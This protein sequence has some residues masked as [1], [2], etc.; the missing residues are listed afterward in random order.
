MITNQMFVKFKKKLS[1]NIFISLIVLFLGIG[2]FCF[3]FYKQVI[4]EEEAV[5]FNDI[6][7]GDGKKVG[8]FSYLDVV[9]DA[10]MF[11]QYDNKDDYCYFVYDENYYYIIRM[12]EKKYKE[13]FENGGSTIR[14]EGTVSPI[15]DEIKELAID[16]FNELAEDNVV[17]KLNFEDYF[18]DVYL[19]LNSTFSS[20]ANLFIFSG[21]ITFAIGLTTLIINIYRKCK[22]KKN[23]NKLSDMEKSYIDSELNS[24]NCLF[25]KKQKLFLTDNY[26]VN[27]SVDFFVCRYSDII[28]MY[29]HE[30]Y[31]NGIKI[32]EYI[33]IMLKNGKKYRFCTGKSKKHSEVLNSVWSYII[34][35]NNYILLGFDESNKLKANE[36]VRNNQI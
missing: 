7:E 20:D 2:L 31:Y 9:S 4:N 33:N 8:K 15:T 34:N 35:K 13:L 19:N 28:W 25:Y 1:V 23:Y 6:L 11:A 24:S 32:N 12:S 16:G 29:T 30:Q 36:Y 3:G 14:V 22:F 27:F 26:I 18:G 5:Y 17:N 10:Y 21:F